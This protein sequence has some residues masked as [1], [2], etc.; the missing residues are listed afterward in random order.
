MKG[1]STRNLTYMRK[2]AEIYTDLTIVQQAA[3]LLPWF[4]NCVLIEKVKDHEER[5]WYIRSAVENGWSRNVLVLQIDS[6]LYHRKG[7]AISNFERTLP[8]AESDLVNETLKDPY[9]F[10]FLTLAHDAHERDLERGLL[11]HLREFFIELGIGF[12]FVGSQYHLEVKGN[13]LRSSPW[14]FN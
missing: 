7:C 5:M 14:A 11:E 3:A 8:P 10:E 12:A 4:H 9:N 6:G 2:F 13:S 1:L